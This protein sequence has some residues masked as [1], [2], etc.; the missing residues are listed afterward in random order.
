MALT[1]EQEML[2][3]QRVTN[4]ARSTGASYLLW[5]FLGSFGAHRFYLGRVPSAIVM[6]LLSIVGW[7]T[8]IF[9]VGYL[10]LAIVGLWW[11]IDAFLIPG[12]IRKDNDMLR[13]K[14]AAEMA[15]GR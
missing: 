4:E 5:F 13:M 15:S 7:A 6:L 11:I 14:M 3:E 12:M 9:I 2:I 8:A 10:F 1:T